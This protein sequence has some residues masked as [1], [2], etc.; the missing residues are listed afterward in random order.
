MD[1]GDGQVQPW[2]QLHSAWGVPVS[3]PVSVGSWSG[4][5][6]GGGAVGKW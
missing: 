6:G 3:W 2:A 4:P 1:C 5:R